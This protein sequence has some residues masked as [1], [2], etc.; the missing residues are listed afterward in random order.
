M[1]IIQE[2]ALPNMTT[3]SSDFMEKPN[4]KNLNFTK[5][6]KRAISNITLITLQWFPYDIQSR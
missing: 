2:Y 3:Y 1:L 5:R 6:L 4:K